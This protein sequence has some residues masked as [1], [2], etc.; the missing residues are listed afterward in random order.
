MQFYP[1]QIKDIHRETDKAVSISFNVPKQLKDLFSFKAGQYITLKTSIDGAEIR[2]DYSLCSSP[3]SNELKVAIKEVQDGI[4]STYANKVLKVG[5]TLEVAPPKGR[6]IFEPNNSEVKNIAALVAGS[7]ITPVL[8]IIK[9]ALEEETNGKVILVYGNKTPKETMFLDELL[10]LQGQYTTR[11]FIQFVY[12][13]ADENNALFGRIDKSVV[14]Y[15][16]KNRFK[17]IPVDTFY[18]CGP[19]EMIHPLK[20]AL[21]EQGIADDHIHFELFKVAEQSDAVSNNVQ[22][23]MTKVTVMLDD[24]ESTFEMSPEQSVLEA[25]LDAALDAPYSCQGGI[26]STCMARLKKGEVKM[27]Q[28][29][30][31][32]DGEVAEGFILTCQSHP[33]TSTIYVDYDDI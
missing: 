32:T 27:R 10:K 14:N 5:D 13:Q 18:I 19:E 12:S 26:C 30:I 4:F 9:C 16:L 8:S 7:G 11:F 20:N 28:N 25:A 31:L 33:L 23:V 6:F 21:T 2:R 22:S 29:N 24:E 15:V 3:R 1:L 17:D